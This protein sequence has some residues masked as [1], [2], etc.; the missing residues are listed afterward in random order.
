M[1]GET[2]GAGAPDWVRSQVDRILSLDVDGS[3]FPEVGRRDPT[4]GGL[5]RRFSGLRPVLFM[6]PYEAGAW[7]LIANRLRIVQAARIKARMAEQLGPPVDIHGDLR[8]AF[9][10]PQRLVDLAGFEGL[11]GRKVER[12]RELASATAGG[13]LAASRLRALEPEAALA[14]LRKLPG[15]GPF[16]AELI[17]LRGAGEP[18]RLPA[19]EPRLRRAAGLAYGLDGEASQ[20]ELERR[21][22]AWRPYRTWVAVLLRAFLEP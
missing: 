8:H 19:A 17:L 12:L 16:S 22:D 21:S 7:A 5:Q 14:Q 3:G 20:D 2:F 4:I 10:A 9:P 6:S 15:I 18:D 13:A 1:L 11:S